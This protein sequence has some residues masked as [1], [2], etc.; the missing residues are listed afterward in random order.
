VL[1]III[2]GSY[3]IFIQNIFNSSTLVSI[4]KPIGG[5]FLILSLIGAYLLTCTKIKKLS[6][7]LLST[8]PHFNYGKITISIENIQ[9][10]L[11]KRKYVRGMVVTKLIRK[12][13]RLLNNSQPTRSWIKQMFNLFASISFNMNIL[14]KKENKIQITKNGETITLATLIEYLNSYQIT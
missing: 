4:I 13:A 10:R 2:F 14:A 11:I 12:Y 3:G 8:F 5:A 9:I 6:D 7:Q 1:S